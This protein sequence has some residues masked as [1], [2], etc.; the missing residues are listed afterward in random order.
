MI[1]KNKFVVAGLCAMAI[2]VGCRAQNGEDQGV[3][4]PQVSE[5]E[6]VPSQLAPTIDRCRNEL[7]PVIL[8]GVKY[9]ILRAESSRAGCVMQVE[10]FGSPEIVSA[11]LTASMTA[12]GYVA[13]GVVEAKGGERLSFS[14]ADGLAASILLR[15]GK[16]V[17]LQLEGAESLLELHWYSP[18]LM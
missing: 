11:A 3:V 10:A 18:V 8:A 12:K 13:T 6:Q 17:S 14:G 4:P 15:G 7:L 9:E 5:P 16:R 1:R 2:L